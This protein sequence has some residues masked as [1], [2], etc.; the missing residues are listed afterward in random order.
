MFDHGHYNADT[1]QRNGHLHAAR[2]TGV[3]IAYRQLRHA[4]S[5]HII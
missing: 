2:E 1:T 3:R 4:A 5:V